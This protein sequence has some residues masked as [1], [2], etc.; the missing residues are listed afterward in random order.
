MAERSSR[1]QEVSNLYLQ[2]LQELNHNTIPQWLELDLTFQQMKVLYIL[3]QK[4]PLKMSEL[5]DALKVSMPTITGI[6]SRLVDRKDGEALVMRVTSAEDRREV[7]AH[8][9]E[10]GLDVTEQHDELNRAL[11]SGV[12]AQLTDGQME[13]ARAG[14]S[15]IYTA[16]SEQ[17]ATSAKASPDGLP[18]GLDHVI[19]EE[20]TAE[21]TSAAL[22]SEPVLN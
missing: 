20:E 17:L 5:S 13:D 4:G 1:I 22:K 9:T 6:I 12:L 10:A 18:D 21:L 14:L 8:L 7:R 11:L 3:R 2:I 19:G 15:H 16:L